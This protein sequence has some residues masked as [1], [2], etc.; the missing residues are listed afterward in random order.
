MK[1]DIQKVDDDIIRKKRLIEQILYSDEDIIE[2]LD[3]PNLD[4]SVPED[5]VGENIFPFLRVPGTQDISK[6]FITFIIDDMGRMP[7]NQVMKSQ[8]IQFVVFVHKDLVKTKYGMAR[9]DLLGYLIRDI[10]NLSNKLGS[11][12]ELVS[13]HEGITDTDFYT[14]TLKFELIDDNSTKPFRTNVNEYDRIVGHR[15]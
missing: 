11:Q 7:G 14:R 5:Y 2:I 15:R 10:F 1:R 4:P 3:N 8:Y 12:M 13:N 6:N 9:H